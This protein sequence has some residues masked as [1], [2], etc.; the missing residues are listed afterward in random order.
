MRFRETPVASSG[1]SRAMDRAAME[2]FGL[3]GAALMETASRSAL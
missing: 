2:V 1:Q 3:S